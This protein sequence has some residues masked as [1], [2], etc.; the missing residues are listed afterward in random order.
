MAAEIAAL[1]PGSIIDY[2]ISAFDDISQ[3]DTPQRTKTMDED[4]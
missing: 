3:Y 2:D 1:P 4:G